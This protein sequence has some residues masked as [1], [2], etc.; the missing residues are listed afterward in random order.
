MGAGSFQGADVSARVKVC[1]S[2]SMNGVLFAGLDLQGKTV[3]GGLKASWL[4]VTRKMSQGESESSF[5]SLLFH[6]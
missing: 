3:F 2:E 5:S 1:V 4:G 6:N